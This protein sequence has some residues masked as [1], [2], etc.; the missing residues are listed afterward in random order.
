MGHRGGNI[1]F[2]IREGSANLVP[3]GIAVEAALA[4]GS[5]TAGQ[6]R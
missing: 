2:W 1:A 3:F 4:T 5:C 6:A